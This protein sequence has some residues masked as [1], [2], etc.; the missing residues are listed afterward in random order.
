M[1]VRMNM[2]TQVGEWTKFEGTVASSRLEPSVIYPVSVRNNTL[3]VG[4]QMFLF[5]RTGFCWDGEDE[6]GKFKSCIEN[7]LPELRVSDTVYD[8]VYVYSI[9]HNLAT[10]SAMHRYYLSAPYRILL[11]H[12]VLMPGRAPSTTE[13]LDRFELK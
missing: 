13:Q 1:V 11:K 5:G 12:E 10:D 6:Q 4:S 3:F 7:I 2:R 9:S 8:S